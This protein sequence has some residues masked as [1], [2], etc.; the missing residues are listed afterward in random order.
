MPVAVPPAL[1]VI[2]IV[3]DPNDSPAAVL[4]ALDRQRNGDSVEII[5][6]DGRP[7]DLSG[8]AGEP[9]PGSPAVI[10]APGL[11]MPRLKARG[12]E[13]ARGTAL[14]FLEPKGVPRDGWL[15]AARRGL[16]AAPGAALGGAV[17]LD[18]PATPANAAAFLFEYS[19][20]SP[21][22]M[23]RGDT[24]DLPGN[25]MV[26]PRAALFAHCGDILASEGLNKPFCQQRLV[27]AGIALRMLPDMQIGMKTAHR[28][29]P[30]LRSRM[31]YARCF[32]GT[33]IALCAPPRRWRYRLGSPAVPVLILAKQV[34]GIVRAR[35]V[36]RDGRA[37]AAFAAL[38]LAWA[39]GEIHGY[40]RGAGTAC[41]DLY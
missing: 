26:L 37:L 3:R 15:A 17:F 13:A 9:L 41:R 20:F 23:A 22:Q 25:N 36:P 39:A 14:A 27:G 16:A 12:A 11:N 8:R 33:R 18:A 10:R 32:G 5:V 2:V 34:R 6:A 1:S 29:G 24:V 7:T 30:L 28:I 31:R 4:D 19:A 38:C 40:W 35:R 21:E